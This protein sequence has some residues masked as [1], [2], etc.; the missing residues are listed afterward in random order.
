MSG[1][2]IG[3]PEGFDTDRCKL[4]AEKLSVYCWTCRQCICH[5]CALWGGN[6]TDGFSFTFWMLGINK[7]TD[8]NDSF[9][10][11]HHTIITNINLT[12]IFWLKIPKNSANVSQKY[13][14]YPG[15]HT[16]HTFKPLEEIYEQHV[17][18]I[19]E[20]VSL[21]R[22]RLM[23]LISLVQVRQIFWTFLVIIITPI[24]N[25]LIFPQLNV[26]IL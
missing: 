22:R 9:L 3:K 19:K 5:Q 7:L 11:T 15:T 16:S 20:E 26:F 25:Y 12:K 18:H 13:Q 8:N 10:N 14:W 23:E 2:S 24:G 17:S 6:H 21:L 1:G 4:H